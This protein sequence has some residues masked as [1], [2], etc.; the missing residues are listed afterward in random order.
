MGSV[1]ELVKQAKL[2]MC[3]DLAQILATTHSHLEC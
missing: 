1:G 2:P 3:E